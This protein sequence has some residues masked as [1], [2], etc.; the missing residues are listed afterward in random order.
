LED[1]RSRFDWDFFEQ[2]DN[3]LSIF[4]PQDAFLSEYLKVLDV[5]NS[6]HG[7]RLTIVMDGSK[8]ETVGYLAAG[9]WQK[10]ADQGGT[11]SAF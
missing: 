7:R 8:D 9:S 3:V 5:E 11:V 1:P 2:G 4:S 6:S 10:E